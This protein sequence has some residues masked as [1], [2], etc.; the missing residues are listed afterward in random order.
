MHVLQADTKLREDAPSLVLRQPLPLL[1]VAAQV[2]PAGV[3]HNQMDPFRRFQRFEQPD[4]R[5]VVH[6]LHQPDLLLDPPQMIRVLDLTLLVRFY[7]NCLP[8]E[9]VPRQPNLRKTP[10]PNNLPD[11]VELRGAVPLH[12]TSAHNVLQV[13]LLGN[14]AE[15]GAELLQRHRALGIIVLGLANERR[16]HMRDRS[17]WWW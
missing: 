6:L 1:H 10:D 13:L 9:L 4:Q 12:R 2:P 3:L 8:G 7:R 14:G 11:G 16:R 15:L 17:E 5:G